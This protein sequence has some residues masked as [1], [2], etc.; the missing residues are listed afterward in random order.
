MI[1][2]L[3]G[4]K[5]NLLK[6]FPFSP[7][8]PFSF[9]TSS[10]E[11]LSFSFDKEGNDSGSYYQ[12]LDEKRG[13]GEAALPEAKLVASRLATAQIGD[14]RRATGKWA[15]FSKKVALCP[16]GPEL[17]AKDRIYG[18]DTSSVWPSASHLPRACRPDFAEN[19]PSD[20]FP[21]AQSPSRGRFWK[22]A[23]H[24]T[25]QPLFLFPIPYCLL[26]IPY[27]L[28]PAACLTLFPVPSPLLPKNKPPTGEPVGG[29]CS[30]PSYHRSMLSAS[31][32]RTM[33]ALF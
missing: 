22:V 2:A 19:C 5:E 21:G 14:L 17:R 12:V 9:Q 4:Q 3:R 15:T 6:R 28:L 13:F 10:H 25:R 1:A 11:A 33:L 32:P 20:S 18:G 31:S 16:Q 23:P 30:K 24:P 26:P 27:S 7:T 8:P 29:Y